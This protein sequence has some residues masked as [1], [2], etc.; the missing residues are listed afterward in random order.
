MID[1]EKT[2]RLSPIKN[3]GSVS[4]EGM[5]VT[6]FDATL[7][8][9]T[10]DLDSFGKDVVTFAREHQDSGA[11]GIDIV[12]KSKIVSR[13]KHGRFIRVS[14]KWIIED[15]ESNNGILYNNAN[16]KSREITDG[17]FFRIDDGIQTIEEGVLFAFSKDSSSNKWYTFDI[18]GEN[19]ITIG[20][21]AGCKLVLPH[22]SVSLN[23]AKI[24]REGTHF[25]IYDTGS[26]NGV[27]VN[28]RRIIG[29]E[30]LNE[31][32]IINITNTKII[33]TSTAISYSYCKSGITVDAS[34]IVIKRGKGRKSFITSNNVSLSV[35]PGEL[36]AV[37]GG[38]GAGK[39][40]I[41][42]A[43]CGYL[44]PTKGNVYINGLDLYKN[45]DSLKKLIGYVPQSDIVYDNL[46]LYD[47]LKFTAKLR[48][49]KDTSEQEIE[50]AI[51]RAIET[52]ELTE[53]KNSFIKS[54]SGGQRKRASIAVELLS[55]PNLLFLDEPS[56]GLDPGT[57]R[58]LM[59]SLREMANKGKT[60]ILVTHST[61]QLKMCDKIVFMGK[62]GNLTFYGSHDEAL[63]FFGVD[64][65]VDIY[66]LITDNAPF[67]KE[68]YNST[69]CSMG[70]PREKADA[71]EKTKKPKKDRIQQ[72]KVMS[73]RYM[74][75]ITNDKMRLLLLLAIPLG[76]C[77]L[78]LAVRSGNEFE[79]Y[80]D[81]TIMLFILSII[82]FFIGMC[83]SV[84]E[85]CKERNILRRE[86]MTGLSLTSYII[87]KIS[88]LGIFCFIQSIIITA[89]FTL[90]IGL[91]VDGGLMLPSIVETFIIVFLL[92]FGATAT[93]LFIS[94]MFKN[95][96]KAF[97]F[98]PILAVVQVIFSGVI[99]EIEGSAV[100]F[101]GITL[102]H[103]GICA[104]GN[105]A[106][107]NGIPLSSGSTSYCCQ[108]TSGEKD[109]L[110]VKFI[111]YVSTDAK[112]NIT[113]DIEEY[114]KNGKY[115][116]D[117]IDWDGFRSACSAAWIKEA[118]IIT[119]S[120]IA[121]IVLARIA[122]QSISREKS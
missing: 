47:M 81:T 90:L 63:K 59:T 120:V 114:T 49:P 85:I 117:E 4:S 101:A 23:H 19:E 38:S 20:R 10:F 61:L 64:D 112:G 95:A 17:D 60:I 51:S 107:I 65:I 97:L 28:G 86:Y 73:A 88:V 55:D 108:S 3:T 104:L 119:V 39:S 79:A 98:V 2:T 91:P 31:K 100:M 30:V 118:A 89:G 84:Q 54:L 96:D 22:V 34:N 16:I 6:I 43:M 37:I 15:C 1:F 29:K 99:F 40:T 26:T 56:S 109:N 52:V 14:G 32:D 76:C 105:G 53:K 68:K 48:L 50:S 46:S 103:W 33:F 42:N 92:V 70:D 27:I 45:F 9:Q 69:V 41:L 80:N 12:L 82:S 122:I 44:K 24:V 67:W 66:R 36:V 106:A 121:F 113:Y 78:P 87:S 62:G 7:P 93:G 18:T 110:F 35:K 72:F 115:V 74:R 21:S 94:A 25:V 13:R 116:I 75:L 111:D 77:L 5:I 8:P 71:K 102:C 83:N 58:N 57:E 11:A